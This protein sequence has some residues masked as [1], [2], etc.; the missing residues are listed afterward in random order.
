MLLDGN[1]EE[2]KMDKLPFSNKITDY[3]TMNKKGNILY[4]DEIDNLA[5]KFVRDLIEFSMTQISVPSYLTEDDVILDLSNEIR[6]FAVNLLEN[7]AKAEF[8]YIDENY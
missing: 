2:I 1:K 5:N 7:V 4:W 8:P 6:D 3:A